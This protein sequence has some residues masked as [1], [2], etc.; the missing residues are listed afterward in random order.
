MD[1]KNIDQL[2]EHIESLKKS[3]NYVEARLILEQ[4]V[5][6]IESNYDPDLKK[7][8]WYFNQLSIILKKLGEPTLAERRRIQADEI[9][10]QNYIIHC[11]QVMDMPKSERDQYYPNGP[12][13]TKNVME[14][15]KRLRKINPELVEEAG[16]Q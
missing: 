14:S 6:Q 4:I 13:P 11:K 16:L 2:I 3:G 15:A 9:I 5:A 10:L 1:L 8:P 12:I 7:P